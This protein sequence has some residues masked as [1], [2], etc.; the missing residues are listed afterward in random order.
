MKDYIFSL[1]KPIPRLMLGFLVIALGT[2]LMVNSGIGLM[3]WGVFHWGLTNI[4]PLTFGQAQQITGLVIILV[5]TW[6]K[7]YPGIGT[8]GNMIFVGLFI[9]IVAN[10]RF[11]PVPQGFMA[12]LFILLLG[13]TFFD[14][15]VYL[16]LSAD[17]GGGPRD[18]IMILFSEHSIFTPGQV[19]IIMEITVAIIGFFMGGLLG[20]GTLISAITG[21]LIL[22]VI[23]K[24]FKYTPD[25]RKTNNLV[26]NYKT[27]RSLK[28]ARENA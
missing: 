26:L 2:N 11:L 9:D 22:D 1:M 25:K 23:F 19:K 13:V 15:G 7:F 6:Y 8:I 14:L 21:G 17:L 24:L 20:I 16:Y 5:A 18:S 10:L 28:E 12:Q 3:P 27:L 4:A